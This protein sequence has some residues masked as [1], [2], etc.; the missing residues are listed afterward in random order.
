MQTKRALW[1]QQRTK[2]HFEKVIGLF[3][4]PFW[5]LAKEL[6]KEIVNLREKR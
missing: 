5:R 3:V 2:A 1:Q 6:A 4:S